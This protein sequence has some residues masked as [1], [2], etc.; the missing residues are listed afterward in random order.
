VALAV[1]ALLML[2]VPALLL[3]AVPALLLLAAL[4][5]LAVP[6]LLLLAASRGT[7]WN[8]SSGSHGSVS[9][10]GHEKAHRRPAPPGQARGIK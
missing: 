8:R 3:L 9:G 6:A 2:A 10:N 4:L 5:M 1:P 7:G